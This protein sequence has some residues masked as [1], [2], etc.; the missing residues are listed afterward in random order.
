MQL[1]SVFV[2]GQFLDD[3]V[4]VTVGS[5]SLLFVYQT[6]W[7]KHML[8]RYGN[9]MAFLDATYRTTRYALPLFFLVVKTNV[10]YQVVGTFVCEGE[11]TDTITEALNV[12]KK[13]NP[14]LSPTFF[15]TDYSN[16]E[17]N[18]IES[19]F[20]GNLFKKNILQL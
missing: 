1:C 4:K 14:D 5:N 10:D 2:S 16:E 17:I 6:K 9:E 7:Q 3:E 15:M 12:L 19:L 18:A 8:A 13:W 20:K 11:S